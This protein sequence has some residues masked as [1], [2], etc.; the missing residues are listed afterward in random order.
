MFA[1]LRPDQ[2]PDEPPD[3]L[4]E[5]GV[6]VRI[7]GKP[8][9]VAAVGELLEVVR[10]SGTE[11]LAVV[12]RQEL[13]REASRF[14]LLLREATPVLDELRERSDSV[15]D[16]L[17]DATPEREAELD[18]R[19]AD[20]E[21]EIEEQLSLV[22]QQ[23]EL[24]DELGSAITVYRTLSGD[25]QL[26]AEARERLAEMEAA[27]ETA[28]RERDETETALSA[29]LKRLAGVGDAEAE[30]RDAESRLTARR[31]TLAKRR[32]AVGELQGSAGIT[33][34]TSLETLEGLLQDVRKQLK[35]FEGERQS[36]DVGSRVL[37]SIDEIAPA[38]VA[39]VDDGLGGERIATVD[40]SPIVARDLLGGMRDREQEITAA[41][42]PVRAAELDDLI[43]SN[44][45]RATLLAELIKAR[46]ALERSD[47]NHR[48][49]LEQVE[50]ARERV[51][52]SEGEVKK[53]DELVA[54]RDAVLGE[55]RKLRAGEAEL[56]NELGTPR[57]MSEEEMREHLASAMERHGL[58]EPAG[59]ASRF[60]AAELQL[61]ESKERLE[62]LRR[63]LDAAKRERDQA[64]SRV[65]F[66]T[67]QVETD[68]ALAFAAS[69]LKS[70]GGAP[71][72]LGT[73]GG[74][75]GSLTDAL[76]HCLNQ[77]QSIGYVLDN[78][79]HGDSGSSSRASG[80]LED[81]VFRTLDSRLRSRL[82]RPEISDA[83][84]GGH[85]LE[86]VDL[87]KKTVSWGANGTSVTRPIE[88]FSTGEQAFAFTQA[89]VLALEKLE[90]SRDRLL[91]LDEFGAFVAANRRGQL[92]RFL[93]SEE[94]TQRTTQVLVVL[95][96]RSNY[97]EELS[98]T[99]GEL[100]ERY[101]RRIDQLE[102]TGYIT[103]AFVE[104]RHVA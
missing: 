49:S 85:D 90:E 20:R 45:R 35:A 101:T 14:R 77:I 54:T 5:S 78:V 43:T 25:D 67:R 8:A 94:V 63:D 46:K 66:A 81:A 103:E 36:I 42:P 47:A 7:D 68:P 74:R 24:V 30:L 4:T 11:D 21:G 88:S 23:T 61:V 41:D 52:A 53:Y 16:L 3:E 98:E 102:T 48:E 31:K 84:F 39:L 56:R 65:R 64:R 99:R 76:G 92:A 97:A 28:L 38:L 33:D 26:P 70:L 51:G 104:D 27:L 22:E 9:S 50:R 57:L 19:V 100:R 40:G 79:A 75:A 6:D 91:V 96:L 69:A 59:L 2:W 34:S 13:E 89:R 29:T 62:G 58:D 44:T 83:L 18:T 55:V 10:F 71:A 82:S 1:E 17:E 37:T 80:P 72:G 93:G 95:P 12:A 60:A 87:R 86:S 32:Q 73:L 15:A